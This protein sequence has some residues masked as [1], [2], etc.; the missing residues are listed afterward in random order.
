MPA[1][2]SR[3]QR[4]QKGPPVKLISSFLKFLHRRA[5]SSHAC[6]SRDSAYAPKDLV[7]SLYHVSTRAHVGA[8]RSSATPLS[9]D[10]PVSRYASSQRIVRLNHLRATTRTAALARITHENAFRFAG[11]SLQNARRS[12][13]KRASTW[14]GGGRHLGERRCVEVPSIRSGLCPPGSRGSLPAC[15]RKQCVHDE[16]FALARSMSRSLPR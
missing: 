16:Q 10:T 7:I 14:A 6:P 9:R 13:R 15:R 4:W 1:S 8:P 12:P 3:R 2:Q 11:A 5:A